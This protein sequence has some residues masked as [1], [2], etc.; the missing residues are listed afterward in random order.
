[1]QCTR[2]LICWHDHAP[3]A[4]HGYILMTFSDL[5]NPATHYR[6]DEF[7]AKFK[8]DI[9][10][11]RLIQKPVLYLI[12]RCPATDQQ[13]LYSPLRLTDIS[14]LKEELS[15][16]NGLTLTDKLGFFKGG[17]RLAKRRV[18]IIFVAV[19]R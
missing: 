12:A 17:F 4:C 9:Y 6:D 5:C 15:S 7:L 18:V 19:A 1:M 3:L 14:E 13:L 11:Q 2:H 8:N 10:A 16:S